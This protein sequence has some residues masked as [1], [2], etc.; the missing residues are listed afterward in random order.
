M[1]KNVLQTWDEVV[2]D[3]LTKAPFEIQGTATRVSELV[4]KG[5]VKCPRNDMLLG[6]EE[7]PTTCF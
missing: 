3:V 2:V 1:L 6:F 7:R 5:R 4:S